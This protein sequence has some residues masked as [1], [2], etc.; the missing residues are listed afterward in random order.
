MSKL[1]S[2]S[3]LTVRESELS[4]DGLFLIETCRRQ[5]WHYRVTMHPGR[6]GNITVYIRGTAD[7]DDVIRVNLKSR[8]E[9][10]DRARRFGIIGL[11]PQAMQ[12]GPDGLPIVVGKPSHLAY[13][14]TEEYLRRAAKFYAG[15]DYGKYLVWYLPKPIA[16]RAVRGHIPPAVA[17]NLMGESLQKFCREGEYEPM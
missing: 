7:S 17:V 9:Y 12:R 3:S 13:L 6:A 8:L 4:Q 5:S 10:A 11:P 1:A 14:P 15:T 16:N 2:L